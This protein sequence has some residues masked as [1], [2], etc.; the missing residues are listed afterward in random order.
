MW[1]VTVALL[2]LLS[3]TACVYSLESNVATATLYSGGYGVYRQRFAIDTDNTNASYTVQ[4]GAT[5]LATD[6]A[7]YAPA[8]P[9]AALSPDSTTVWTMHLRAGSG[10]TVCQW[11]ATSDAPTCLESVLSPESSGTPTSMVY[12]PADKLLLVAFPEAGLVMACNSGPSVGSNARI[13]LNNLASPASMAYDATGNVVYIA[14]LNGDQVLRYDPSGSA[15]DLPGAPFIT[16]EQP[17][18]VLC[19]TGGTPTSPSIIVLSMASDGAELQLFDHDGN[20]MGSVKDAVAAWVCDEPGEDENAN[21][22]IKRVISMAYDGATH[23]LYVTREGGYSLVD[24]YDVSNAIPDD[25]DL[26]TAKLSR[27]VV[28]HPQTLLTRGAVSAPVGLVDSYQIRRDGAAL[29]T[30]QRCNSDMASGATIEQPLNLWLCDAEE[31]S[32][33]VVYSNRTVYAL[34]MQ[35]ENGGKVC[36]DGY[37]YAIDELSNDL[38]VDTWLGDGIYVLHASGR[39]AYIDRAC[40]ADILSATEALPVVFLNTSLSISLIAVPGQDFVVRNTLPCIA[41]RYGIACSGGPAPTATGTPVCGTALE[42]VSVSYIGEYD[43]LLV[44]GRIGANV[45]YV[46]VHAYVNDSYIDEECLGPFTTFADGRFA[47]DAFSGTFGWVSSS[48]RMLEEYHPQRDTVEAVSS[49]A[50][51]SSPPSD[52]QQ[53]VLSDA[54]GQDGRWPVVATDAPTTTK[55]HK[56]S[57]H[58]TGLTVALVIIGAMTL[59]LATVCIFWITAA[60]RRRRGGS[61]SV[62]KNE[63]TYEDG[64]D[65]D[66]M[67]P[68]ERFCLPA[69]LRKVIRRLLCGC[70]FCYN[71]ESGRLRLCAG[72]LGGRVERPYHVMTEP[73]AVD[74]GEGEEL[75]P[76]RVNQ[77]GAGT[78]LSSSNAHPGMHAE[79]DSRLGG[80]AMEPVEL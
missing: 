5:R 32:R 23:M 19:N 12:V 76:T 54:L 50:F 69:G 40:E 22:D 31:S 56:P 57:G 20:S 35:E 10:W 14:L 44:S 11:S 55:P 8:A 13:W 65:S 1:V 25:T 59:V 7:F 38:I 4:F 49:K 43:A 73:D 78:G 61:P 48:A 68:S 70:M 80:A 26:G 62:G 41:T 51:A 18:F 42:D 58:N 27:T 24:E 28:R 67:K 47:V 72:C 17:R 37:I 6:Y 45:T 64:Q 60:L 29:V 9:A 3:S 15:L 2:L 16:V 30:Y 46:E 33:M 75:A 21:T 66:P 53:W 77:T 71:S 63:H 52:T 39:V 34:S 36:F 74:R 79:T